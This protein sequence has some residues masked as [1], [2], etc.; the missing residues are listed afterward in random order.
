[1]QPILAE[2]VPHRGRGFL[3]AAALVVTASLVLFVGR[4]CPTRHR[5]HT[6]YAQMQVMKQQMKQQMKQMKI[7]KRGGKCMHSSYELFTH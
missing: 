6:D 4:H 2:S 3:F 5:P 1:M 7:V